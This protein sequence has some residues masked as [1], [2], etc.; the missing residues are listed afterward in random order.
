MRK[1]ALFA[2]VLVIL[3]LGCPRTRFGY[4]F[5][6][7]DLAGRGFWGGLDA[8]AGYAEGD[9][10][11]TSEQREVVEPDV[12]RLDGN[13]LYVLN[14]YRGLTLVDLEAQAILSQVPTRGYPREIVCE[15]KLLCPGASQLQGLRPK[16]MGGAFARDALRDYRR[17]S[18]LRLLAEYRRP[19]CGSHRLLARLAQR[20]ASLVFS[21]CAILQWRVSVRVSFLFLLL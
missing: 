13:T 4:N 6:S 8:A 16:R 2:L 7:A 19:L 20:V 1:A 5:T 14:Q 10:E 18:L 17:S 11:G 12:Y 3:G 21:V 15:S 9:A